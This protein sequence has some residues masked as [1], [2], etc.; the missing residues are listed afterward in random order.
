MNDVIIF[1]E[2]NCANG[3]KIGIATLNAPKSLNALS[4][5]MI[6]LLFPQLL[7]WKNQQ[8]IAAVLLQ[9]KGE[10]AFCAGGDIVH[11]YSAAKESQSGS[12]SDI[13]QLIKTGN[14]DNK[15][16]PI[17]QDYFTQEYKLDYLIHTFAK[18]FIVWGSGI[19][20]GGGLGLLVGGSHRIV[21]ETS[22]IAMPEISIGLFPDVGASYFL[23]QMPPGIGLF[24]ALTGA[25][26]NSGDAKYCQLA[27]FYIEQHCKEEL[28]KKLLRLNFTENNE[29]NHKEVTRLL[30][31]IESSFIEKMPSSPMQNH[32]SLIES[33]VSR[34]SLSDIIAAIG[35]MKTADTWLEKAQHSLQKGSV[36]SAQIAYTQLQ[37]G[38]TMTLAECFK[39]ELN[40]AVKSGI[41]GE[42]SEGV[43]ALLIDKDRQPK[44]HYSSVQAIDSDIHDWFFKPLWNEE[45]HPLS[46][47]ESISL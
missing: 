37:L 36:M 39:M 14:A 15:L 13:E 19:V 10:K 23:N 20:M 44:W 8:D 18:P 34:L 32:Q 6:S 45:E 26:I 43:R 30:A 33:L 25:S 4:K 9:G 29:N 31:D 11:L 21:T 40:L 42:F 7:R 1:E 12:S 47:L 41:F 3:K 2:I 16:S 35:E 38:Q 24:L 46:T 5:E 22:R 27:D 28:V 17:L